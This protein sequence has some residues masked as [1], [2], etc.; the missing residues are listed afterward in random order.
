MRQQRGH[1]AGQQ[2]LGFRATGK[3]Q[4]DVL[5]GFTA[6]QAR[7]RRQYLDRATRVVPYPA[8]GQGGRAMVLGFG[9]AVVRGHQGG[10]PLRPA[11]VVGLVRRRLRR[12]GAGAPWYF[13]DP[14]GVESAQR[15]PS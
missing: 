14:V 9:A 10:Q 12:I 3:R 7:A 11:C 2:R 1:R 13:G 5:A 4:E 15:V 6:D 8:D